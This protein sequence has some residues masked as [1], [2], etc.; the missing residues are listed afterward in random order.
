MQRGKNGERDRE[1]RR[2]VARDGGGTERGCEGGRGEEGLLGMGG[3]R[4]Y[5]SAW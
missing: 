5:G 1:G 2:G 3:G 4:Q